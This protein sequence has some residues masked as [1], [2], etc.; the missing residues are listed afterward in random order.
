M[1]AAWYEENGVSVD[2]SVGIDE[3]GRGPLAGPVVV[4]AVWL[5]S[6]SAVELEN[7]G[8]IVRDS[9]KMTKNQRKKVV[10]W[11]SSR[12]KDELRYSIASASVEEI[13][14]SNILKAT[15]LAMKKAYELLQISA[16]VVL[17]DGNKAP[18][19]QNV[20]TV[21]KGDDKVLSISLA[22][23]IAKE[24]RDDLMRKLALEYP[25]YG[26]ETNVGYGTARH[27]KA[28]REYGLTPYHRRTFVHM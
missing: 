18:D 14:D 10:D 20:R 3:V 2:D 15:L 7:S 5:S 4:A 9:K 19:L 21:V 17:V 12:P 13:D 1:N 26:W 8:L 25:R 11:I 16:S 28:V 6:Q 22:S 23:I 24:Y 27:V